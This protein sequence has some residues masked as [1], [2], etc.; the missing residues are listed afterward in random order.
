MSKD[1]RASSSGG[2]HERG[3]TLIELMIVVAIIGILASIAVPQYQS[4]IYRARVVEGLSMSATYKNAVVDYYS[5]NNAFPDDPATVGLVNLTSTPSTTA[6]ESIELG[7][8]GVI[9]IQ[10]RATL[11]PAGQNQITLTP[12]TS[13]SSIS[14]VCGGNLS[15]SLKPKSCV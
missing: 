13:S 15:A 8:G 11:A 7:V 9:T 1:A 4:Y 5:T 6:L 14:W 10:F 3:F 12:V 2:L